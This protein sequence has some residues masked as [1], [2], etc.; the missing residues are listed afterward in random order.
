MPARDQGRVVWS[1][2]DSRV[3]RGNP[4]GD[5][6][7]RDLPVYV[8]PGYDTGSRRYPV[9]YALAGFT[10]SGP[11]MLNRSGWSE[12]LDQR[13]DRLQRQ[14]R[15]GPMIVV[16][17]DCFTRLGGSQYVDSTATGAYARHLVREIVPYIDRNFRTLATARHRG[18][19]G[20]SSGGYGALMH[21]MA[22]PDVFGAVA[23]HSGDMA[24]DS[25]Y[26][27]DFP[28][29]L[30]QLDLHR[31]V[32]GFVRAFERAPRKS[33]ELIGAMNVLAMAACYSPDRRR[34]LGI[35]LPFDAYTGAVDARV[36]RRWLR[37]DPLRVAPSR[38]AALRRLRLLF[39][40]CGRRDEFNLLWGARQLRA[41]LRRLD[42]PHRYEEF[43]DGHMDLSYRLDRSLPLLWRAVRPPAGG[44]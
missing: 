41:I 30:R 2:I 39:F 43:D 12:A 14:R 17:P 42:V 23:C 10:G 32:R 38:A 36:W 15:I 9:L 44:R 19:F 18:I 5:P 24:F 31:G 35:A 27:P 16:M 26:A 33:G 29:L 1:R 37:F 4:L 8:P 13:L 7:R 22:R 34:P 40:D 25:C 3:L 28:K 20:K 21:G 11:M 6:F